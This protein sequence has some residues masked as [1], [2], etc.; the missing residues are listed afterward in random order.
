[1]KLGAGFPIEPSIVGI[2]ELVC[3]PDR[4]ELSYVTEL[5][6]ATPAAPVTPVA[7]VAPVGPVTPVAPVAPVAPTS[8]VTPPE[9]K[10]FDAAKV[11]NP[12][13][14]KGGNYIPGPKKLNMKT[15]QWEP[16]TLAT[17]PKYNPATISEP[18]IASPKQPGNTALP[19][20]VE[21]Y[22]KQNQKDLEAKGVDLSPTGEFQKA[23]QDIKNNPGD[24]EL[25]KTMN[26]IMEALNEGNQYHRDT[27][28]NTKKTVEVM[29]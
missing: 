10:P 4:V 18:Q 6:P 5:K 20:K 26:L 12:N 21:D 15:G 27:A 22:I 1:L 14:P 19:S 3:Q 16:Y 24:S 17:Q 9:N 11:I 7:P 13:D 8:S 29:Q 23:V 28:A 2:L 25:V